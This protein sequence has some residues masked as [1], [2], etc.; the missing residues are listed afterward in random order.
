MEK[1]I[2]G[3]V[4][5]STSDAE[6]MNGAAEVLEELGISHEILVSSVHR[7]PE[8]TREWARGASGRGI[9][10]VIAGAGAAAHLAGALA[11]ETLLPVIGVPL[12]SSPLSGFDA[13]LSTVQMPAGVPVATMG[14]GRSGAKNAALLAARILAL[15]DSDVARRLD[16]YRDRLASG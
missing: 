11:S 5:G 12:A 6:I 14:V 2:V 16:A 15:T 9:R 8:R 7:N 3:I 4:M 13:L 10:I 1:P